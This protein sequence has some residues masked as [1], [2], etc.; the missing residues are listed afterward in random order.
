MNRSSH[1]CLMANYNDWMNKKVYASAAAL[2]HA[3]L[4]RDRGAFF[5]S[6]FGTLNHLMV[7]DLIW[8]YRLRQFPAWQEALQGV[9]EYARPTELNAILYSEL[10]E[11]QAQRLR[12]DAI[13]LNWVQQ[14]QESDLDGVLD[15]QTL[16][17]E[18]ARKDV[19]ALLMHFFNHQTHHR[20]QLSTLLFQA[21]QDIGAT[22]LNVIV[23]I[24]E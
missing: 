13:I 8:L 21:G 24:L 6:I 19:Y 20:G 12:L 3:E 2:S 18:P 11:L 23:P 4:V 5:A 17:G 14:I 16:A 15:Y 10:P 1:V 9:Q 22:D 7:A